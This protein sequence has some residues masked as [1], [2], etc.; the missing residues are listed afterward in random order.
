MQ[1]QVPRHFVVLATD[2]FDMRTVEDNCGVLFYGKEGRR[3]QMGITQSIAGIDTGCIHFSFDP[4][5]GRI[6]LIKRELTTKHMEA[7]SR[8]SGPQDSDSKRYV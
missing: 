4:G 5:A 1:G 8:C 2:M 7:S 6:L 3:T